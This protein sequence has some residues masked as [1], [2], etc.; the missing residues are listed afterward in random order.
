MKMSQMN[1]ADADRFFSFVI[2]AVKSS[3]ETGRTGVVAAFQY[4]VLGNAGGLAT[5]LSLVA[6]H[7]HSPDLITGGKAFLGGA[8]LAVILLFFAS[9]RAE[10]NAEFLANDLFLFITDKK[11]VAFPMGWHFKP[12]L[13]AVLR[14]AFFSSLVL[15]AV[16]VWSLATV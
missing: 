13:K 9:L 16:G 3:S 4:T 6:T 14:I 15:F 7:P 12:W 8:V 1:P 2:E 5:I 10:N 11:D